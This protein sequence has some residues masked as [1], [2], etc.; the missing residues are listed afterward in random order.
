MTGY[1]YNSKIEE[2]SR[3]IL[4]KVPAVINAEVELRF[5]ERARLG[6]IHLKFCI[7]FK[8]YIRPSI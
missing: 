4:Y 6:E 2:K 3:K 7:M 5:I 8:D 1:K